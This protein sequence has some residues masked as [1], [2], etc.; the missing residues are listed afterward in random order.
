MSDPPFVVDLHAHFPMHVDP[1]Q[2][3]RKRLRKSKRRPEGLW[4]RF[5]FW[6]LQHI[7]ELLNR[8][9]PTDGHAVTVETL[10]A[11]NVG[12]ALSVAYC[13]FVELDCLPGAPPADDHVHYV[14][15]LLDRVEDKI[16]EDSRAS[17]VRDFAQLQ[18]AR[19]E[20]KVAMIHA[21]EGGFHL[22]GTDEVI[23]ANVA[24][25]AK[26]GLGYVTVAHLFV[27]EVA[28]N[29]PALPFL[30]DSM[31]RRFFPQPETIGLWERGETLIREMVKHGVLVDLTHM[32]ERGMEDTFTLLNELDPK[33]TI[34]VL[35]THIACSLKTRGSDKGYA[36]NL[37]EKWVKRVAERKGVCGIM[38]CEHYLTDEQRPNPKNLAE[39]FALIEE[40]IAKLRAWG[41]DDVL[42]IGSD[43]DG[44]I[45]PA[46]PGLSSA[47]NHRDLS[48]W[49]VKKYGEPLA[50][51]IC[52]GNALRVFESAWRKPFP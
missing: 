14:E 1:E 42:A 39:S 23:A 32:S 52:H 5:T 49:L 47:R 18:K 25:L 7:D 8:E 27:R 41:G 19:A 48:E 43:L 37:S 6:L 31:Y 16:A 44:F 38:Y 9:H 11:G 15:D 50:T 24:K 46:L 10:S 3:F 13:P 40:H 2:A 51:K 21:I 29:M 34:P 12:V 17:L 4:D 28:T 22:G 30:S 33:K 26:K 36:Y 35:V 45:K 20:G